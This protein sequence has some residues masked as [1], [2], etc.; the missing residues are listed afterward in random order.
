MIR[1]NVMPNIAI[2]EG[3]LCQFVFGLT[4]A[5]WHILIWA[6]SLNGRSFKQKNP[7]DR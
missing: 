6:R 7:L 2:G 4:V 5:L 1:E 3:S